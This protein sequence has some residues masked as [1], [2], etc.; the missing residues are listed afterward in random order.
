MILLILIYMYKK[1]EHYS[2]YT[3]YNARVYRL[4]NAVEA[5]VFM[6]SKLSFERFT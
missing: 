4:S 3:S 6:G 1:E 5:D 2:G